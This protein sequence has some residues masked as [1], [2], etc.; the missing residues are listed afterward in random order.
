MSTGPPPDREEA[1]PQLDSRGETQQSTQPEPKPP[2]AQTDVPGHRQDC[3]VTCCRGS[4][5]TKKELRK[6]ALEMSLK[7]AST[8][9]QRN[10]KTDRPGEPWSNP[11]AHQT[12]SVSEGPHVPSPR[13][14]MPLSGKEVG[15]PP[16]SVLHSRHSPSTGCTEPE[17]V[18]KVGAR[19]RKVRNRPRSLTARPVSHRSR[20]G[21]SLAYIHF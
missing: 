14:R 19:A 13:V 20:D 17:R 1:N 10:G 15:A 5:E 2:T 3:L 16:S 11:P 8:R 12:S 21:V 7:E 6:A 4:S 9:K 18:R